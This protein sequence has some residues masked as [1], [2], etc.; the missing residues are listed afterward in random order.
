[1]QATT[2][3]QT[4]SSQ[5]EIRARGSTLEALGGVAALVLAILA[6]VG[7]QPL[8]LTTIATIAVGVALLAHGG[9]AVRETESTNRIGS[10]ILGGAAGVALGILALVGVLPQLLLLAATIVLGVALL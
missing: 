6:L 1:M 9:M 7:F 5:A 10:E 2:D 8:Y 3:P 4:F